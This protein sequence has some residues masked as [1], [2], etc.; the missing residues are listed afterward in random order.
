VQLQLTAPLPLNLYA[1]G[2][3]FSDLEDR[4]HISIIQRLAHLSSPAIDNLYLSPGVVY[5]YPFPGTHYL[6]ALMSRAGGI[7]PMF[8]YHKLRAFW[9]VA[10]IVLLHGC[11]RGL[12]GSR[13]VALAVAVVAVAVVANGG[14]SAVTG[15]SWGQMAPYSHASDVAM[16]VLLP[17]LL[18]LSIGFLKAAD[19]RESGFLLVAT[20]GM[21]FMLIVV[22]PREVVQFL[23]YMTVFVLV[24]VAARAPRALAA[25]TAVLLAVS[26]GVLLLYRW[27]YS[28]AVAAVDS[29][30]AERRH[31]RW[32]LFWEH[33]WTELLGY[34]LPMLDHYM[35]AFSLLF[36][37]W[38][39]AV[40]LVSPVVLYV[41]RRHRFA[42]LVSASILAYL[43]LIR[44]PILAIPY[45]YATYFEILYTPV[46]NVVFFVY[47]LT[48]A[49]LYL[50]ATLVARRAYLVVSVLAPVIAWGAIEVFG[51]FGGGAAL[52]PDVLF[53]PVLIGHAILLV[54]IVR[55]YRSDEGDDGW[56]EEA[57][58]A[59]G[60][61]FALI[62]V[63]IV[64]VTWAPES[65]VVT[66]SW[67]NRQPTPA[68]LLAGLECRE[69]GQFCP[70][71]PPLV[72]LLQAGVSAEAILAV[73]YREPYEPTLFMPQQVA[74]WTGVHEG[75][76][77]PRAV[78]P[79]Y[80][81]HLDR[82]RAS[83]RD[84]PFFDRAETR[85]E[86]LAFIRD[87]R[88]THV[89]LNPMLYKETKVV[90]DGDPDQFASLY[91]DGQWALFRVTSH[92]KTGG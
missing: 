87:L 88:I 28:V 71:P 53:V 12:L 13:R 34:P 23:V 63:P 36:E 38:N 67:V 91:D 73:D 51:R 20:L 46:R 85:D 83:S 8:L 58:P 59:W 76:V 15:M 49:S 61:A 11:A 17:G 19:R 54:V 43:L 18:L 29:V 25:R 6:M 50:A 92:E 35:P 1:E 48:G 41:F 64:V 9:G 39:P 82:A 4:I 33:S 70:P 68:T 32:D 45:A 77:D 86:R 37:R 75:L 2:P 31:G 66:R 5:T 80:L 14:F 47:L 60:L 52:A 10:A 30:V 27:W 44:L 81:A 56:V 65:A 26:I 84:Q 89:L 16:G 90:F 3:P 42:W 72:R 79:V 21:G 78:F 57:R 22:H 24:L 55:R 62:L 7:E 74:V 40:I 69:D